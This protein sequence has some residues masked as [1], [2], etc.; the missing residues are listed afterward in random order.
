MVTHASNY[1]ILDQNDAS[2]TI[3]TRPWDLFGN[4]CPFQCAKPLAV[5]LVALW[6]AFG[7]LNDVGRCAFWRDSFHFEVVPL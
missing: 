4:L 1:V 5:F 2:H 6:P 3:D 7:S